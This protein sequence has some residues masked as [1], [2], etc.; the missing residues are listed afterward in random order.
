[1]FSKGFTLIELLIG[2]AILGIAFTGLISMQISCLSGIS[3]SRNLTTAVTLAQDKMEILKGLP[4]DHPDLR[5]S[6]RSNNN[7]LRQSTDPSSRDHGED[8]V[9]I[10]ASETPT[11]LDLDYPA[12]SR[13]WNVAD[14][15]PFFGKKT[16]V[17]I[18]IWDSQAK[19]V[20]FSSVI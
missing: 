5:D 19:R 20:I 8:Q 11:G 4:R 16:V 2:M 12:Y 9:F 7:T 13:I 3:K 1:M 15:T 14:N 10:R 6:N 17:V 18:V